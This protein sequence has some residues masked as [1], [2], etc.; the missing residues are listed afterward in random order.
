MWLL[1]KDE[2]ARALI[3][4]LHRDEGGNIIV[5]YVAA[6]LLL[7]G[8]LWA[9]IGTGARM[10][11]KETIQSSADAAAFSAAV[12]KAKGLNIIAFCNL[13]MALLLAIIMLLRLIKGA[14]MILV[15]VCLAACFDIFGGEIL[16]G[17]APT[18]TNLYQKYSEL[19]SK[20]E[21]RIMDAMKGLSKLERGVNETFPALAL[22]EAYRVGT[23]DSYKRNF[24]KGSLLTIAWPLPVGKDLKLPTK[25]GTWD[26]LCD[27]AIGVFDRVLEVALTKIGLPS[28]VAGIFGGAVTMLL[29]PLKGVLCGSGGGSS[30]VMV[31]TTETKTS[32]DQCDGA[33]ASIWTGQKV[34]RNP[35]GSFKAFPPGTC[36]L[37]YFDSSMCGGGS[38]FTTCGDGNQYR[39]L[40]FQSCLVKT[41]AP[42]DL[43]AG[44]SDK[45]LPLDIAD[46][47]ESRSQVRAFT[48]LTD[49]NMAARRQSVAVATKVKTA[50]PMLNELLGTAQAEF[51]AFNG[52]GH[53]DL[54]HMDWR[55]R[56]TR[57]T[58][59]DT[60]STDTGAAG[61]EGVPSGGASTI[62]S[63]LQS[64]LS[65]DGASVLAD[66]F[67]LH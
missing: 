17:F 36:K 58:F 54:W 31:D 3:R 6:S 39:N 59:G 2:A 1:K 27:Q 66:Q 46:D 55:A 12:I 7:I 34:V 26:Q 40:T 45:P 13:V 50:A 65:Q 11:Q 24:G 25:D 22:V 53:E 48:L 19:E 16:C 42:A 8:M 57:F 32:C 29:K 28:F 49:S 38:G 18:A 20:L 62:A 64:F 14:L 63:K 33:T 9:I 15:G 5:L 52:G 60:S 21:P 56:L 51:F 41:K 30:S 10:V 35:D 37:D 47:W 44:T 67:M 43:G 23:H 4:R 61:G